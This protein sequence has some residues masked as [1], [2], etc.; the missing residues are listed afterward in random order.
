MGIWIEITTLLIP[1]LNDSEEE[2][3]KLA[4]FIAEQSADIPWHISRFHPTY[5]M[6]NIPPTPTGKIHTAKQIGDN[7]GL[8][9]VYTGNIPGDQ[10]E[11]TNCHNCGNLLIDRYGFSIKFNKLKKDKCP[12]C[13]S[14]I[15]GVWN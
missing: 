10:G 2:L 12:V 15:P 8:R 14:Y 6:R 1:G 11:K 5:R 13:N 9:Y 7:A 3:T 4:E